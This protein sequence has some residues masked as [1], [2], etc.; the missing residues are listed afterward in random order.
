MEFELVIEE[1]EEV[2]PKHPITYINGF[3]SSKPV[4]LC[5]PEF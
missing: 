5:P 1:L 4:R 3:C 2:A